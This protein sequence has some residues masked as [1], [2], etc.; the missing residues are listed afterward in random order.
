MSAI[1]PQLELQKFYQSLPMPCPY[2]AGRMERKLFTRLEPDTG[3]ALNAYLTRAGFRRSH[4]MAYRPACDACSACTPIRVPVKIFMPSD[5]QSRAL[6]RNADLTRSMK[7]A[8]ATEE[9]YTLFARYQKT[10]HAGGDMALMSLRDYSAMIEDGTAATRLLEWRDASGVLMATMLVDEVADGFSAITSFFEP[11]QPRRSL[12]VYM[13]LSLI[14]LTRQSGADYLY[15]GYY[16]AES[17]KMSY[18]A[19][20]KPLEALGREGWQSTVIASDKRSN[21]N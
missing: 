10:R 4:D 21:P 14:E 6:R 12:G 18:K 2:L 19:A 16:I 3:A 7:P 1:D 17:Q 20:F 15:L 9:Q 5:S 8:I 13:V 11:D